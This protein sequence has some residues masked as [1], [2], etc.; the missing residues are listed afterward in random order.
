[1]INKSLEWHTSKCSQRND[2][3]FFKWSLAWLTEALNTLVFY[4]SNIWT[5]KEVLQT[6]SLTLL[7]P[8]SRFTAIPCFSQGC[9]CVILAHWGKVPMSNIRY[10]QVLMPKLIV[11]I[12]MMFSMKPAF[13]CRNRQHGSNINIPKFKWH[14][15]FWE[16][17][18]S[19]TLSSSS[20]HSGDSLICLN[21]HFRGS[22]QVKV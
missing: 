21:W 7:Q 15:Y 6:C 8:I 1:M 11:R 16:M 12:P 13:T 2:L 17:W 19:F 18:C 10:P 3:T 14:L 20:S 5:W 4:I 9:P 22:F